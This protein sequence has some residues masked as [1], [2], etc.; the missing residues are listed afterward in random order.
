MEVEFTEFVA[1][2]GTRL[3]RFSRLLIPDHGEAEDALQDALLRLARHW[4][5]ASSPE[6]YVRK[7]LVNLARDRGRRRH[8]VAV[9]SESDRAEPAVVSRAG[10]LSDAIA[11]RQHLDH[12][13]GLLPPKQ[14]I[15]VVLRIVEDLGE[16]ETAQLMGCAD[17]T[18]KSNLSRALSTLRDHVATRQEANR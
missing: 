17:G 5:R 9:P 10:D 3:L 13:L 14:R 18:V 15:T 2:A 8:L 16:A 12:L 1:D 11:A 4:H 7:T 6:A